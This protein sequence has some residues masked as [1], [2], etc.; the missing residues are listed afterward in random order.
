MS[1]KFEVAEGKSSMFLIIDG[2]GVPAK[3]VEPYGNVHYVFEVGEGLLKKA[4]G[5]K[6]SHPNADGYCSICG[7]DVVDEESENGVRYF[8]F[9]P[10][11][12]AKVIKG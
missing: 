1:I 10:D 2:K 9:C 8:N 6:V 11:C 5:K 12:G 3:D 4:L 7:G